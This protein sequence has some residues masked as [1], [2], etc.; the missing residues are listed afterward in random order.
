MKKL[1]SGM[2]RA[3]LSGPFSRGSSSRSGDNGSQDSPRSSSFVPL[4]YGIVV[5]SC[6]LV[7]DD[8]L[9]A[10]NGDDISIR[11]N[12][13]MEKYKSLHR[14]EFAHTHIYDMNLL[15]RVNLDEELITIL[16]TIGWRKL[17]D[18]P[19]LCLRLLTL[20]FLMTFKIVEKNRKSFVKFHLFGKSFGC[21]IS[22]FSE[23]LD[24]SKS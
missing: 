24:F 4:P 8:V 5:S 18:E 3:L 23:L 6:Y 2:K 11:T 16:R 12:D 13:E 10:T 1:L 14:Q 22:R 15:A 20:E 9:A 7:H 17:Y 21:D 19:R